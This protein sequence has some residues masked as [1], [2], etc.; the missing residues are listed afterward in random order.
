MPPTSTVSLKKLVR[1]LWGP[2]FSISR[3]YSASHD[4]IDLPARDGQ[5]VR[6]VA[7]GT[8]SFAK[9]ARTLS[10]H[11]AGK[12]WA[13]GGGNV[14]N[15]DIDGNRTTQYAHLSRMYVS[16]GQHVS[17]GQVIG[18][19]GGTGGMLKNGKQGGP[20]STFFGP[21]LHFGL[22]DHRS[23]K[24]VNP[25]TFLLAARAGAV[26]LDDNG[27]GPT[28]GGWNDKVKFPTGHIL[29]AEDTNT[30]LATLK[31][32]GYFGPNTPLPGL[33]EYQTQAVLRSFIGKP[34]NKDTQVAMQNAFGVAAQ[35]NSPDAY[36]A[37]VFGPFATIAANLT[38]PGLWVRILAL[39]IGLAMAGYGIVS[40]LRASG[41]PSYA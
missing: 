3:W 41:E 35:Q 27:G 30:I 24:M 12:G 17:K 28:L 16:E 20:G 13:I 25:T 9:D 36:L 5:P 11:E 33:G 40:V 37:S 4:G 21:H 32:E 22:W 10:T 29:T 34:W 39:L 26:G 23:N 14:V 2:A 31:A 38:D 6:A 8:V 18:L 7:A 15:I 1:D 19:V